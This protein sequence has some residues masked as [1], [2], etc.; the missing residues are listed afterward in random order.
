MHSTDLSNSPLGKKT[1]YIDKYD[2]S[3]L[4]PIARATQ[5]NLD[6][7]QLP[8]KGWDIWNAYEISWL[9]SKGKPQIALA[10]FIIPHD[11]PN[12]I[13]SKSLKLYLNSFN[14]E[15]YA[16]EDDVLALIQKDLSEASGSNVQI[17]FYKETHITNATNIDDLDVDVD[18]YIVDSNLLKTKDLQVSESLYSNLLKSNCPV[19]GQPDW[20]SVFIQYKG[21][22]IDHASLLKYI[23]SFRNY[24]EFHE[25][26][27][28]KIF[29]DIMD[30]CQPKTLTVYARYTRRGGLDINPVRTNDPN[31]SPDNTFRMNRQ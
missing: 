13:E 29:L 26:C 22:Q 9:N 24:Q 18:Q 2:K 27:V 25:Q 11:S 20:A 31:Y 7:K 3:L 15:N 8:F 23:I 16:S 30:K 19:T 6:V 21:Q 17:S 5:R 4:F 10:E 1:S 12:L 14:N 28:E